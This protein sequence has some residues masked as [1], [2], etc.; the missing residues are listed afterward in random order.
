MAGGWTNHSERSTLTSALA[1]VGVGKDRRNMIGR[2]SPDGSDDYVRTYK[3]A[4]REMLVRFTATVTAGRSFEAFDEDDAFAQVRDR[5]MTHVDDPDGVR[6]MIANLREVAM[7]FSVG[8][9]V[10]GEL[11]SPTEVASLPPL[12]SV[13]SAVPIEG[14]DSKYLVVYTRNRNCARLHLVDGCWRS[15]QMAF[16]DYELI[17]V[18]PPPREVY[19]VICK[20]CWPG[21]SAEYTVRGGED[22]SSTSMGS[23]TEGEETPSGEVELP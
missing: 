23:T 8:M 20:E 4:V 7:N 10:D 14:A 9:A 15:R 2:W 19:N 18:D 17:D 12:R 16:A 11:A 5:V 21:H 6:D 3:A 1:A 13:D 22:A